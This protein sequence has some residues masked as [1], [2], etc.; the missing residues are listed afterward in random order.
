MFSIYQPWYT[1]MVVLMQ[2]VCFCIVICLFCLF[3]QGVH[4]IPTLVVDGGAFVH[5]GAARAEDILSSLRH[6]VQKS[7]SYAP[8][9]RLFKE[10]MAF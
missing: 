10:S 5:D 1:D 7:E 2:F 9:P 6:I 4:S 3:L 8:R